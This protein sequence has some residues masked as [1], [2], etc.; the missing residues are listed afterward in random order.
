LIAVLGGLVA[1]LCFGTATL[2]SSRVSLAVGPT[3]TLA[4][5]MAVGFFVSLPAVAITWP[6]GGPSGEASARLAAGG[7][8]V[9]VGLFSVYAAM[10]RADVS[11]VAPIVGTEGAIA[12]VIAVLAG[13]QLHAGVGVA[14]AVIGVGVVLA[15][16]G[17]RG[18]GAAARRRQ[19]AGIGIAG[20]AA[21]VFGLGLFV[22]GDV[23]EETGAGLVTFAPRIVG[24]LAVTAPLVARGRPVPLRGRLLVLAVV[25]GAC[26]AVGYLAFAVGSG[27][28]IAV[29]SVLSSQFAVVATIGGYLLFGERLRGRQ[30]VGVV[31][32]L[33]G[34]LAV[35]ILSA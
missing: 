15:A 20:L 7:C 16:A 25:A 27:D 10:R 28:G 31:A 9:V 5:V 13:E 22:L 29:A 17:T 2:C 35:S 18:A 3:T 26:E 14:L 8:L 24:V 19:T 30:V 4:W 32:V 1:A 34:V 6:D 33:G 21:L 23:A 11:L 12:A